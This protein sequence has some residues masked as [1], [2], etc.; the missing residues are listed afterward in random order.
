MQISYQLLAQSMAR[1]S[2]T[3]Q[4][5]SFPSPPPPHLLNGEG[6]TGDSQWLELA[7]PVGAHLSQQRPLSYQVTAPFW[8]CHSACLL[9]PRKIQP[10]LLPLRGK[11]HAASRPS[12]SDLEAKGVHGAPR[13]LPRH[14]CASP[15][16]KTN[17]CLHGTCLAHFQTETS[18][19]LDKR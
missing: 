14:P 6:L 12:V 1:T 9:E 16:L 5:C 11:E 2:E 3:L 17:S 19:N 15:K 13:E 18:L 10:L 4:V 7:G 8:E